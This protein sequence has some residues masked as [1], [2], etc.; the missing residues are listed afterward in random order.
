M[1]IDAEGHL[2]IAVWGAGQVRRYTP[3][4][5][6]VGVVDVPAPHTTS[7]AFVGDGLD[8]LLIT[9]GHR[10]AL[11]GR[12]ARRTPTRAG[13]SSPTSASPGTRSDALVRPPDWR[14][15]CT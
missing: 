9:I 10:R 12:P 1:C 7:V 8:R 2:W 3:D 14:P 15:S 13:C 5:E 6:L 11:A 4:G